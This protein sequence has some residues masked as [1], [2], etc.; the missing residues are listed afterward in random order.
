MLR[1]PSRRYAPICQPSRVADG[2]RERTGIGLCALRCCPRWSAGPSCSWRDDCTQA[3]KRQAPRR[4]VMITADCVPCL[5]RQM[6]AR[7]GNSPGRRIRRGRSGRYH[8]R[9]GLCWPVMTREDRGGTR[10]G[11]DR[12]LSASGMVSRT[13]LAHMLRAD[14]AADVSG[15]K[16]RGPAP[17]QFPDGQARPRRDQTAGSGA[18]TVSG[19]RPQSEGPRART[20]T[21]PRGPRHRSPG[22]R[23]RR[24]TRPALLR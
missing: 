18:L 11:P 7:H 8:C 21:Q 17:D 15:S 23:S 6:G 13:A 12:A 16:T 1:A 14:A 5:F 20:T 10:G 2:D 24:R 4:T 19:P 22:P 9:S 3:T